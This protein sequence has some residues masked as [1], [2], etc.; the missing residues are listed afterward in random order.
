M[1]Q[2]LPGGRLAQGLLIAAAVGCFTI[3]VL[4]AA[5][6]PPLAALGH[7]ALGALGSWSKFSHVLKAWIP[8][9]LCACGLLFTFRVNLWNI[10]VEGQVLA[11]AICASAVLRS[12]TAAAAPPLAIALAL[13]AAAGGGAMWA[14][15]AGMLRTRGGGNEIFA[16]LGM[17]FVAQGGVLWLIFGPWRRPG[18]ASMSG[19]EPFATVLWLPQIAGL[20]V[21]PVGLALA[22]LAVASTIVLLQRTRLGLRLRAVGGNPQA[23]LLFGLRTEPWMMTA[24]GFSGG[25]AGLAGGLQA[26]DVYHRLIPS[27]SSNYGYMALLVVMLSAYRAVPVPAVA[28]FFAA[29]AMGSIQLP[30]VLQIDSSLSGVIQ[31]AMVL[32]VL[33]A[34]AWRARLKAPGRGGG[35]D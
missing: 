9:V 11:G 32:A 3:L 19:T 20:R 13:A 31:G 34:G 28:L 35:D 6:A 27:I 17:N 23:A 4:L 26:A 8:L 10:G 16:G 5:G 22:L 1:P 7:I 21:S 30:M 18:V 12:E 29:L 15:I 33:A 24:M 14:A 25:Y 2:A